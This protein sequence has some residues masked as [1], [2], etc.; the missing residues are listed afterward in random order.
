MTSQVAYTC[1]FVGSTQCYIS[2]TIV[3]SSDEEKKKKE[4]TKL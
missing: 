3:F 2:W 1:G 4:D